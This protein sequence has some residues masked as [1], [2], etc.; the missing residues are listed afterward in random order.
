M[1]KTKTNNRF[2]KPILVLSF[3]LV[4]VMAFAAC[5]YEDIGY[6][7]V[8]DFNG[9]NNLLFD[10]DLSENTAVVLGCEEGSRS[11]DIVSLPQSLTKAQPLR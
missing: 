10:F 9:F 5:V 2:M 3:C 4:A 7:E 6:I 1:L 11:T 8:N